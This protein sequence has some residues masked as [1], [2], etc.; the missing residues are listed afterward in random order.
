M[1]FTA[2]AGDP[3]IVQELAKGKQLGSKNYKV[4]L[5]GYDQTELITGKGPSKRTEIIYFAETT[6]GA[7]RIGDYKY[8][9]IDQ[10]GGWLGGTVKPDWPILVNLRLD[11][12]ERAGITKSVN[13]YQWYA[14]EFWRYVFVQQEVA[15]IAK[16]FLEYPPMQKGASF[17]LESLK[18]ELQ[19][20]MA[21]QA[22]Q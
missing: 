9:F 11:P 19:R 18:E 1:T 21:A 22:G 13:Y 10:P 17:N 4:H 15:E 20:K 12:F 5:D 7:V 8:R 14:Y 3:N 16:T 2:A 6:L